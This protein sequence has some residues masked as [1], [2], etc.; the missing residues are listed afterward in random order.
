MKHLTDKDWD[1]TSTLEYKGQIES[2][3]KKTTF[4]V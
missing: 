1:T 2:R 3:E 4:T